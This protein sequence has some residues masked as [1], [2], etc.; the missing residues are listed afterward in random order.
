VPSIIVH[1]GAGKF[2]P[3]EKHDE[4]LRASASAG[5]TLLSSG[6]SAVEAVE[7]AVVAMEDNPIF[8][9][10]Y[11]A[12]LNLAGEVEADASIML[13]DLSA[14][15]V[16]ALT[17]AANPIKAAR[18]VMERTDHVMLAGKGVDEFARKLGL[19][20]RDLR[21]EHRVA[22]YEKSIAKLRT[23]DDV[24]FLPR[25]GEVVSDLELG[26]VGAVAVDAEGL[27]AAATSTGGMT[28]KIPG[29][30]GD[31][32]IIGAGTYAGAIGAVSATGHGEP[33]MRHL[34]SKMVV[35]HAVDVGM[36]RSI[37]SVLE[38]VKSRG[39]GV[40][41]IGVEENGAIAHG[42]TTQ[43]MCWVSIRDGEIESFFDEGG[44]GS[45]AVCET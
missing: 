22:L 20:S 4:G 28:L 34:L 31:S 35:D 41:L 6:E 7:A 30:V 45:D 44:G 42:F 38:F 23:G 19:P 10:G 12:S 17:A 33:I 5:W 26:T 8:N 27:I 15:S 24:R 2:D 21:T 9:A 40:G 11:G 39:F 14:G 43:A 29:R 37:A 1:G 36:R 13:S 16:A 18:L 25:L 3:G 32:A